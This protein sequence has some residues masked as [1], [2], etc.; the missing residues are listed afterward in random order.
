MFSREYLFSKYFQKMTRLCLIRFYT[1]IQ[2]CFK[3]HFTTL[4]QKTIGRKSSCVILEHVR[5]PKILSN[6]FLLPHGT[7]SRPMHYI[8]SNMKHNQHHHAWLQSFNKVNFFLPRSARQD[9]CCSNELTTQLT[10]GRA[11]LNQLITPKM[12]CFSSLGKIF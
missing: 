1:V 10:S 3:L 12:F 2:N 8:N 5:L 6:I 9:L 4:F 11:K 7:F